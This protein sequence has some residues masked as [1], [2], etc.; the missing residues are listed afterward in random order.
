MKTTTGLALSPKETPQSVSVITKTQ[1]NNRGISSLKDAL[2]ITTGVNVLRES[3][4]YRFQSR[5]FYVDQ[6]EEDGIATTVAGSSGNPYRDA[7]SLYDMA[8]YDHVEVVR[9]ATG[10][11]QMNGELGGTVNAVRNLSPSPPRCRCIW[12]TRSPLAG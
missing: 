10:L 7:Q 3:G 1:L 8:I 6:I 2:K 4:R 5:G 12:R 11:T 9:G